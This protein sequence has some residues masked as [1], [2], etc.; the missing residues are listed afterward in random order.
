[1]VVF[2]RCLRREETSL[3][4]SSSEA[5]CHLVVSDMRAESH[6]LRLPHAHSGAA[7]MTGDPS[8]SSCCSWKLASCLPAIPTLIWVVALTIGWTH[9]PP[10]DAETTSSLRRS[11]G[12]H[13]RR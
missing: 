6:G 1:M 2:G 5:P 11:R 8:R 9:L 4:G 7:L 10:T 3:G 12:A 13:E